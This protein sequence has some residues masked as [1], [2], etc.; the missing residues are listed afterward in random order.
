[1]EQNVS[2]RKKIIGFLVVPALLIILSAYFYKE[3][4]ISTINTGSQEEKKEELASISIKQ[5]D[6]KEENFSGITVRISGAGI[7][8]DEA[9]KYIDDTMAEFKAQAD[10]AV[11]DMRKEFGSDSPSASYSIN[12]DAKYLESNK[13]ESIVIYLYSYTGGAHGNSS[14]KVFTSSKENGKILSLADVIKEDKKTAFTEFVK[15][16]LMSWTPNG[17]TIGP[18]VFEEEVD[19]LKLES[20]Q[21]WSLDEEN[22]ILYFSQYEIGPGVLGP[23]EFPLSLT[24]IKDFLK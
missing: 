23:V 13:T 21:N 15:K 24:K 22:L 14:Y 1:M 11:P 20:F 12:I 10:T 18:V 5:E 3:N 9:Q 16:E 17:D 6:I 2:L 19:N 8:R 7:L 4:N